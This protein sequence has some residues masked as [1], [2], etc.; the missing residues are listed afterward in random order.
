MGYSVAGVKIIGNRKDIQ[1]ICEK[2]EIDTIFFTIVNIDNKNKK[3]I[4]E[5]CNK[6]AAKVKALP[7]L[8]EIIS[9][10][11]LYGSLTSFLSAFLNLLLNLLFSN[12]S[13]TIPFFLVKFCL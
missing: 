7:D 1:K 11:N 8:R 3:E 10:E 2:E 12:T 5:I 9:S 6:T 4:L 13:Y